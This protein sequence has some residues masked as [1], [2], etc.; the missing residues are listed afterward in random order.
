M[1]AL[2]CC[3]HSLFCC[4][5]HC[6]CEQPVFLLKLEYASLIP[7]CNLL[8]RNRSLQDTFQEFE[9]YQFCHL[10]DVPHLAKWNSKWESE[11]FPLIL[12]NSVP[13]ADHILISTVSWWLSTGSQ[14]QLHQ[15]GRTDRSCPF[16]EW[17]IEPF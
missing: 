13:R 3:S 17:K 8:L 11:D 6:F 7:V 4:S 12:Y 5:S 15:E 9:L 1:S 14:T 2:G 10:Y 16:P